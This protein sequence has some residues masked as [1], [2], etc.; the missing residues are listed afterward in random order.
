MED[1]LADLLTKSL[2]ISKFVEFLL[3][4][5]LIKEKQGSNQG[6]DLE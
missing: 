1:Q 4:I 6:S 3:Q 5:G 2:G